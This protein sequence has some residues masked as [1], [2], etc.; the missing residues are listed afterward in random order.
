MFS[1]WY[2]IPNVSFCIFSVL[3]NESSLFEFLNATAKIMKMAEDIKPSI[4]GKNTFDLSIETL[5]SNSIASIQKI[6]LNAVDW[7]FEGAQTMFFNAKKIFYI[8]SMLLMIYDAYRYFETIFKSKLTHGW[9]EINIIAWSITDTYYST[10]RMIH[11]I[12]PMWMTI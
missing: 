7:I 6:L 12:I 9:K 4:I 10:E 5:D 1:L 3:K 11:L 2:V 8:V